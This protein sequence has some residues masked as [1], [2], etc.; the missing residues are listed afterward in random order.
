MNAVVGRGWRP[1]IVFAAA[2]GSV[3]VLIAVL[4]DQ[5]LLVLPLLVIPPVVL[6]IRTGDAVTLLIGYVLLLFLIPSILIVG[7]IGGSGTPANILGLGA[8][9]WWGA[10]RLVPRLGA[11]RGPQPVRL[12]LLFFGV[13]FAIS[14]AM[15]QL[16]LHE[17][18][19]LSA[20]NRALLMVAGL[21][22]ISLLA[23]DGISSLHRLDVL[24]KVLVG[25]G[26]FIAALGVVQ[27]FTGYDLAKFINVP[28]LKA[29]YE[30]GGSAYRSDFNRVQA[31]ARHPIEFG[32]VV[33]FVLPLA[34]HYALTAPKG[35]RR[36]PAACAGIIAF[37]LPASV[38]RSA[39]VALGAVC[40][41]LLISWSWRERLRALGV[42]L[43]F[44]C[45]VRVAVPGLVGTIRGMFTNLFSDP[46]T[47]GRTDDYSNIGK[48]ILESPAFG[49]GMFTFLPDRYIL[50]DNQYLLTTVEMGFVGLVAVLI[51]FL[52]GIFCA[53]GARRRSTDTRT[54]QLGAALA[55]SLLAA[56]VT[57]ATFDQFSFPMVTGLI[58]LLLGCSGALWRLARETSSP[59]F[60]TVEL[61]RAPGDGLPVR[62][63]V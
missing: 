10:S 16:K 42:G 20:A 32:V 43:V 24:L 61:D 30:F 2:A 48:F 62:L 37:A 12:A 58:A 33:A 23:A 25:A 15:A 22:G 26:T 54:R 59:S 27:F 28:G 53:R 63:P 35:K 47:T 50:L 1:P 60:G 4:T 31:T 40:L 34:L 13:S 7:P 9:G 18:I 11:S 14:Y 39:I 8:L 44:I 52:V 56:M 17:S 41:M 6:A 36:R 38:S 57:A 5:P 21:G 19:E 46:S 29:N 49:R 45:F 51:L 55:G 3:V